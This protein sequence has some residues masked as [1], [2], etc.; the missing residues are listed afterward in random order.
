MTDHILNAEPGSYSV[1]GGDVSATVTRGPES[2][3]FFAFMFAA[4][5]TF[6]FGII[7]GLNVPKWNLILKVLSFFALAYTTLWNQRSRNWQIRLLGR[8]KKEDYT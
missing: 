3:Q 2:W 6:A 1:S 7:D 4:T 5:V 8:F